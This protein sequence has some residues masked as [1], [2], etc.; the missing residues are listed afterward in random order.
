MLFWI[1][2]FAALGLA[3]LYYSR[4]QPFPEISGRFAWLLLALAA[5]LWLSSTAPRG[6][7]EWIP[8]VLATAIGGLGLIYGVVQMSL[9]DRDVIVA[10][11]S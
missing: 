9:T 3:V 2:L 5:L 1:S 7:G 6:V 11:F 4:H 8:P 10:P